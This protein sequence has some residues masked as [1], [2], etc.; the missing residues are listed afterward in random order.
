MRARLLLPLLALATISTSAFAGGRRQL[1]V[2]ADP[3]NLP[4][5]N[6]RQEGFENAIARLVAGALDAELLYTWLPQRRGFV[7][8][9]LLARQCDVMMEVPL[10]YG[11][12]AAT[13]PYY[14]SSYVFVTRRDRKLALASFDDPALRTLR[15]GVQ[16]VGDD[17]ANTPPA[18]ALARRGLAKNVVGFSVYGDYSQAL[19]QSPIIDAV[20]AGDI[21]VAV[22]WGPLAGWLARRAHAPLTVTPIAPTS[23]DQPLAF[24]IAMGVRRGDA[25]L[26]AELDAV[27]R[28]HRRELASLLHRFGVPL[29]S[30]ASASA[31]AER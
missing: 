27:I 17:Y 3:N 28:T 13:E 20:A 14:R 26:R 8:N 18:A 29:L 21:D 23:S 9:T 22:V 7:R 5:S 25:A 4:Y 1:R 10:G 11:R 15:V 31:R 30:L 12:A 2:C 19:P 6:A 16:I 24:D